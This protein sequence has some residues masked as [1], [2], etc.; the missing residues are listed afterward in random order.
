LISLLAD[1]FLPDFQAQIK[2]EFKPQ[3]TEMMEQI[4][5][6]V[7][8]ISLFSMLI[9]LTAV[10]AFIYTCEHPVFFIHLMGMSILSCLGQFFVYRMIKQFKQHIVPFII[11]TRKIFTI[12][13]S[14]VYYK[15]ETTMMQMSGVFIVF[16]TVIAEFA[17][18]IRKSEHKE[19]K[20]E[21]VIDMNE[22]IET[23]RRG[24][25]SEE[26]PKEEQ[27]KMGIK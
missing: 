20:F 16:F 7:A 1:G 4:N 17:S 19:E 13:L 10:N 9:S 2:S 18:E 11:T 22:E 5:K 27:E 25:E 3:P 15:H 14:I 26:L 8:I 6:W 23:D 12:F 21:K 24:F